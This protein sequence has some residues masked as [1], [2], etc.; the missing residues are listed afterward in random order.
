MLPDE[1]EV[2]ET[3][4]EQKRGAGGA[5]ESER[6][7]CGRLESVVDRTPGQYQDDE[8]GSTSSAVSGIR[9]LYTFIP[10]FHESCNLSRELHLLLGS[11]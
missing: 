4:Q 10:Y 9:G 5:G 7:R 8:T 6:D 2:V 11:R 1:T 3:G